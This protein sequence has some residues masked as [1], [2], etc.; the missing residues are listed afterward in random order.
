[1]QEGIIINSDEF[2]NDLKVF[3]DVLG[4]EEEPMGL[5]FTNKKPVK[6][7]YPKRQTAADQQTS[8]SSE[9]SW[10]SCVLSKVRRARME[11]SAAYF[12]NE[13]YGCLGGAFFMGFK[14]SYEE[15][16]PFL[17]STGIPGNLEGERYVK[18]PEVGQRFY[19][20]FDP[21][22]ASGKYL[23]IQPLSCFK[24][25]ERPELVVFFATNEI[26][27]GL[28]GLTVFLTSEIEAV[29]TPFGVGCCTLVSW[30]R[31][32]LLK[33][34]KKAIIGGFDA[35]CRKYLRKDEVSFTISFELFLEMLDE[36]QESVL[37]TEY[38]SHVVKK[39]KKGKSA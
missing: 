11:K 15:F 2:K 6:G 19:E 4:L 7:F 39:I 13:H 14:K 20:T 18:T 5:Y 30:P 37:G 36:W 38:W 28:H 23:V 10:I 35:T 26:I 34:E 9:I 8:S 32:L 29:Q 33:G 27:S 1:M 3:L 24:K 25:N 12:D 16:E 31:K 21:P 17:L 22:P